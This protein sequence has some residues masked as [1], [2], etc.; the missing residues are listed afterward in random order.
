MLRDHESFYVALFRS[1]CGNADPALFSTAAHYPSETSP[2]STIPKHSDSRD[3]H[4][5]FP[6]KL[7][8]VKDC[9]NRVRELSASSPRAKCVI[10]LA[11]HP[12]PSQARLSVC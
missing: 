8:S 6:R 9:A 12:N 5:T 7:L 2:Q 4:P 3:V 11:T 10:A 1:A